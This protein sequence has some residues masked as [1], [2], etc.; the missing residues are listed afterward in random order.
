[1]L[2]GA[3]LG[4]VSPLDGFAESVGFLG[5]AAGV[6]AGFGVVFLLSFVPAG[7]VDEFD[8]ELL[9]EFPLSSEFE[10]SE[11]LL[12]IMS[13]EVEAFFLFELVV[14]LVDFFGLSEIKS[15]ISSISFSSSAFF[16]MSA[17]ASLPSGF[18]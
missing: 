8:L 11:D 1:M 7:V 9:F 16:L 17:G 12:A 14:L 6:V 13:R 3:F 10:L 15:S 18:G 5:F 4:R 2:G